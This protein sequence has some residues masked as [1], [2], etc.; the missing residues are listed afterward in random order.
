MAIVIAVAAVIVILF[1]RFRQPL[2]LGYL[3]AGMVVGPF[4]IGAEFT[5]GTD[6][7]GDPI[8]VS[9]EPIIQMLAR[10]GIVLLTF[11]IGLEFSFKQLRKIGITIIAAASVEIIL[12]IGIGYQL[13]LALGWGVLESGLLG[14]ML[15]ISSTMIIVRSLKESGGL[16][17][18]KAR[19]VVGLLVVEDFA[20]V[21]ILAMVSGFVT[22]GA[23]TTS[24]I[25]ELLIKMGLFLAASIVV[26]LAVVPRLVDYV[27]RQRST[28]L[29]V[30]T[31]IGLCF[32]MAVFA[33]WIGISEA[34]GAFVM[35]VIVS[36]SKF[37]GDV[38]RRVEPI[39]DLFGAIFFITVGMLVELSL[40]F[41]P[42]FLIGALIITAVFVLSKMF[43]CTLSTFMFGFGARSSLGAGLSMVSIGEFSLMI[44]AVAIGSN[45]IDPSLSMYETIVLVTTLSA[46]IVPYS[47]KYS[48]RLTRAVETR[49]PRSFV[50]M[51]S[52]LNLLVRNVRSRSK[53]SRRLSNEM[54]DSITRLFIYII[55]M[56]TTLIVAANAAPMLPDLAESM[57]IN[58]DLLLFAL[59]TGALV[60]V[61]A[62]MYGVWSRSIRLIEIST[63]EAMLSTKSAENIGYHDTAKALKWVF[64][65]IYTVIGFIIVSPMVQSIIQ[66]GIVFALL[67]ITAVAVAGVAMWRSVK[68][69]DKKLEET[70]KR[71]AFASMD[72]SSDLA[73][74]EEIIAALE[75]GSR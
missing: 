72:T 67:A 29:L 65:A 68:T 69:I 36:E 17:N 55:V 16:D 44:A 22:E 3:V 9:A 6:A 35:G 57:N 59:V 26:G 73:E 28:E 47:V 64:L 46:L 74:I 7:S 4:V 31:V 41:E 51:A 63:S 66:Q 52:Y 37:L 24:Q 53:T 43:S 62:T 25:T 10:L 42:K 27:G 15:S 13:G 2:I 30:L 12:M 1:N 75:R 50:I 14:A 54:R 8:I 71:R 56:A 61:A 45:A 11:S 60:V 5:A 48:D 23:I 58:E 33:R 21:M 49:T 39:R 70:F 38:V 18:E 19:L 34:I 40:F 32:S 20:A